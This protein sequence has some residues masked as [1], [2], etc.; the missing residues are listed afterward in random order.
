MRSKTIHEHFLAVAETLSFTVA[1]ERL[2]VAQPWL[3]ARIRQFE[4]QLGFALFHRTTRTVE[5][6]DQGRALVPHARQIVQASVAFDAC[7]QEIK[8]NEPLVRLGA[9]LYAGQL[10]PVRRLVDAVR[11]ATPPIHFDIDI[12]WTGHLLAQLDV[13][14]LDAVIALAPDAGDRFQRLVLGTVQLEIELDDD[15]QLANVPLTPELFAG[16][17]IRVFNSRRNPWL[18]DKLFGGL[19]D[20]GALLLQSDSMWAT[21]NR[22]DVQKGTLAASG[23]G[24]WSHS[25][26][27]GRLRR[28]AF[29]KTLVPI[30]LTCREGNQSPNLKRL[31]SIAIG[32][33]QSKGN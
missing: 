26:G 28:S 33:T 32:V 25:P 23:T 12:G 9:P 24:I 22:G 30:S 10:V 21:K 27:S 20:A 18:Y 14:Q 6:T 31:W 13:G 4:A 17:R 19:R 11:A 29:P 15:D 7:V 1:A 2:N 5:L 3:S 8:G 16:R